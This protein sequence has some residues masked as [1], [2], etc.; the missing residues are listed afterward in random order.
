MLEVCG[1][2]SWGFQGKAPPRNWKSDS[3]AP[4]GVQSRDPGQG[5]GGRGRAKL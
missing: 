4:N 1:L 2:H 5:I 3:C